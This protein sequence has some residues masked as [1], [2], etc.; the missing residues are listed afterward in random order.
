MNGKTSGRRRCFVCV[1]EGESERE[2]KGRGQ[3]LG[4][5]GTGVT[6]TK[7]KCRTSELRSIKE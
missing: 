4:R 7:L 2:E 3:R 5:K 1:C 6:A